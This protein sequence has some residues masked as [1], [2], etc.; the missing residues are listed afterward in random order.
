MHKFKF[1]LDR[2]RRNI[3]VGG[4]LWTAACG[5]EPY[6]T[7]KR[8]KY[9]LAVLFDIDIVNHTLYQV[10]PYCGLSYKSDRRLSTP[11]PYCGLYS[12]VVAKR[13]RT[14]LAGPEH[15][16]PLY[17][18]LYI[19][20]RGR[21]RGA[22]A[23][24]G[25]EPTAPRHRKQPLIAIGDLKQLHYGREK[26]GQSA[27]PR[28]KVENNMNQR[29]SDCDCEQ[30]RTSVMW[31]KESTLETTPPQP[32]QAGSCPVIG[33]VPVGV[34]VAHFQYL[35]TITGR[36]SHNVNCVQF[37]SACSKSPDGFGVFLLWA[38]DIGK[39]NSEARGNKRTAPLC[40]VTRRNE[41]A[42]RARL[43]SSRLPSSVRSY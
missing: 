40:G 10:E 9:S 1:R 16:P 26:H 20:A 4:L 32:K 12:T 19:R 14:T 3:Q 43:R 33:L 6:R 25:N 22:G 24:G 17:T 7:V 36:H 30:K 8:M 13:D 15:R 18:D 42:A 5:A 23:G 21:G 2:S 29:F 35:N 39:R 11:E 41:A 37:S 27:P 28:R 38:R 31:R 34:F